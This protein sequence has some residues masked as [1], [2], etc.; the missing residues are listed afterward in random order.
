MACQEFN[1]Y[2][3]EWDQDD[4][5]PADPDWHKPP[6]VDSENLQRWSAAIEFLA[7]Q[8]LW[9]RDFEMESIFA[10]H[11]PAKITDIKLYLG[12]HEDYFSTPAPDAYS[13]EYQRIDRELVL[14]TQ[15]LES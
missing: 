1:K 6:S 11:D 2:P 4:F 12:I 13:D 3:D 8:V 15:N 7:N 9:D 14:L 10:D 5:V